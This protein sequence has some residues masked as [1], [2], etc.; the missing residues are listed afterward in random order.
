MGQGTTFRVLLPAQK[1]LDLTPVKRNGNAPRSWYG[2]GPV[3]LV[4]DEEEVREV[5]W[6]LR[7]LPRPCSLGPSPPILP[8]W[9]LDHL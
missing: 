7:T 2:S 5:N 8:W 1:A 4:D 6:F 9:R 3:L